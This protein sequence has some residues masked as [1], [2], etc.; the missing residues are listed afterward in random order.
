[1]SEHAFKCPLPA[2][3]HELSQ[4]KFASRVSQVVDVMHFLFFFVS[5]TYCCITAQI[6]IFKARDDLDPLWWSYDTS[7]AIF[8]CNIPL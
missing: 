3:T 4:T 6:S 2:C 7:D 1:M 5:Y 8:F